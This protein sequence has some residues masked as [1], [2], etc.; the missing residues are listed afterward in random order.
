MAFGQ[1]QFYR[2][3]AQEYRI[4]LLALESAVVDSL[5]DFVTHGLEI[6]E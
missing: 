5:Y 2:L 1:I 6:G 3:D 4:D